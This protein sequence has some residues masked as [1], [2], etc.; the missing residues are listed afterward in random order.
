MKLKEKEAS[1]RKFKERLRQQ[2]EKKDGGRDGQIRARTELEGEPRDKY[3]LRD[4][5]DQKY[6]VGFV[7][8]LELRN[9]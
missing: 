5:L 8:V 3:I 2:I 6:S 4:D 1:E 9:Y 7:N